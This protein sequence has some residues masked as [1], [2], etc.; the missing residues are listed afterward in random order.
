ML[1]FPSWL[2]HGVEMN[3]SN[4]DRVCISFNIGIVPIRKY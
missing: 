3:M 4:E 2:L 1:I